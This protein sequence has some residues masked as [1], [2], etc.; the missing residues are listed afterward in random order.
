MAN[1]VATW[2]RIGTDVSGATSLD[3]VLQMSGLDY[4]VKQCPMFTTLSDKNISCNNAIALPSHVANVNDKTGEV[5][6]IVSKSYQVCNN[7][8]AFDFV[9]YI[10]SDVKFVKAGQTFSGLVYI[11]AALPRMNIL[12]DEF[13]PY[14]ILQNGHNGWTTLRASIAPL[15][16]VCQN[17]FNMAFRESE[18]TVSIRHN[19]TM[20][21]KMDDARRVLAQTAQYMKTL[22]DQ[23]EKYAA[24]KLTDEDISRVVEDLF[25]INVEATDKRV[26]RIMSERDRFMTAYLADDNANFR[27][28]VWGLINAGSDFYT[29]QNPIR[30]TK[31]CD[32]KQFMHVTFDPRMMAHLIEIAS[33][34][35]AA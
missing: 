23:A 15:R 13:D 33:A 21:S 16:I 8:D 3:E 5:L 28:S 29:H 22:N 31:N 10:D 1:R 9:N 7:R 2:N 25:P 6:G 32:E 35:V 14:V 18:N 12:G 4:N 24:M 34:R 11:I 19:S 27:K 20:S 26:Q 30:R 17:Q